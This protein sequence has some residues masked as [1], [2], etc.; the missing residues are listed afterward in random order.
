MGPA[1][2]NARY[3]AD[4]LRGAAERAETTG[5]PMAGWLPRRGAEDLDFWANLLALDGFTFDEPSGW[6]VVAAL[7]GEG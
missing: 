7:A 5:Q 3:H 2:R 1:E 6:S 4:L